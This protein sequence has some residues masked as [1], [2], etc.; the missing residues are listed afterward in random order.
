MQ[1]ARPFG[2]ENERSIGVRASN[3]KNPES[4]NDDNPLRAS[5]MKDLKHPAKSLYQNELNL[6]DEI[7][8]SE[9]DYH[10]SFHR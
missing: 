4:E 5:K 9:E 3:N 6:E 1:N 10:K 2:S 7:I 8:A